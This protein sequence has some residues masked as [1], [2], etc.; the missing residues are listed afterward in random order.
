MDDP[1]SSTALFAALV[2]LMCS[3]IFSCSESVLFSSDFIR[4]KSAFSDH[5]GLKKALKLKENP[6]PV[7]SSLLLG[8][9]LVNVTFSSLVATIALAHLGFPRNVVEL[10]AT[11][12]GTAALLLFGEITPKLIGTANP[13]A[14]L[15]KVSWFLSTVRFVMR[16][17]AFVAEKL[18]PAVAWA[19][20]SVKSRSDELNE[21]RLMAAV[22]IGETSGA[23]RN[24]EKEMIH[25]VIDS[26]DVVV[27][28]VMVPRPDMIA[29]QEDRSALDALDLMLRF[30]LSRIPVFVDT[31]DNIS[32]VVGIKDLIAFAGDAGSEGNWQDALGG[33]KAKEF[34]VPPYF[35]PETKNVRSLL[36][37]M[38]Q[39]G[40]QMS[41]V[42]D[43]Y[44]GVSGL[45]TMEDLVEEIVGEIRDEYD[46]RE[47]D[48]VALSDRSWEVP[49]RMSLIDLGDYTGIE[50]DSDDMDTVA[51]IVMKYLDRMPD[52]GD[53]VTLDEPPVRISVRDVKG[54][55][56]RKVLVEKLE[57]VEGE[58]TA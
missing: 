41:I 18:A 39:G 37:E 36:Q 4:L 52:P 51:G 38:R 12:G 16:P 24:D 46:V 20:P 1:G 42:V 17:F 3:S 19:L 30:G 54:P 8:N 13:E 27:T 14:L 34:A 45:I 49:G 47:A 7:L 57:Q 32:G 29:L 55:K 15:I 11:A 21:A 2:C 9:T 40:I 48:P 26:R 23:I 50:I 53:T 28:E 35:I 10:I 6:K 5:K 33:L 43:E 56:I 44:D 58:V 25:G 22:D 31:R